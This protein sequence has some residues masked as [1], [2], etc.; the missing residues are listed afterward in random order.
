MSDH[1]IQ[2]MNP[3]SAVPG[4]SSQPAISIVIP[5]YNGGENFRQCLASLEKFGRFYPQVA[6]IIIVIDGECDHSEALARQFGATVLKLPET[7]GPARARNQGAQIA[8]GDILFFIDADVTLAKDTVPQVAAIFGQYPEIS[9]LIGSYD[10]RPGAANF[11]SQYKNLFHHYTHQT[12]CEDGSTFWGACGAIR[13]EAFWQIGG[14]DESYRYPSVE[15][16]ELGYRLKRSGYQIRLCKSVQVKHLK[17]WTARSL[18]RAEIFYRALPWTELLW[19]DRAFNNDLNLKTSSRISLLLS[20]A[21]LIALILSGWWAGALGI[22]I[23]IAFT[24]VVINWSV[25][26]FFYQKRGLW[27]AFRVMPWHWLYFLYG[28]LAFALGTLRYH[29]WFRSKPSLSNVSEL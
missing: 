10:D 1:S 4:L 6:E 8:R 26:R 14:F 24:L 22:G 25:Y 19:R 27:F 21:L 7:G 17:H 12:A 3:R 5:V 2:F 15:D 11:L 9:A 29:L 13:R 28:G 20:Y 16:I 18:L 23:G